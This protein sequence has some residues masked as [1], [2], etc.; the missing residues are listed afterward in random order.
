MRFILA[1]SYIPSI[2]LLQAG[3]SSKNVGFACFSVLGLLSDLHS[4][5]G[6]LIV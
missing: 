1:S 5:M 6:L 2:P 4:C 3:E